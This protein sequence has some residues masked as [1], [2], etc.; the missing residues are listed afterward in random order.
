MSQVEPVGHS[1]WVGDVEALGT[2]VRLLCATQV[3]VAA[4]F[5][6]P[7]RPAFPT[8]P[9]PDSDD[10]VV[11]DPEAEGDPSTDL[12]EGVPPDDD[13]DAPPGFGD[14]EGDVDPGEDI[15]ELLEDPNRW[16]AADGMT[17]ADEIHLFL[18]VGIHRTHRATVDVR[19][20]EVGD[21]VSRVLEAVASTLEMLTVQSARLT[22]IPYIDALSRGGEPR[23]WKDV[24]TLEWQANRVMTARSTAPKFMGV[25]QPAA[26][27]APEPRNRYSPP[28]QVQAPEPAQVSV[29]YQEATYGDPEQ[30]QREADLSVQSSAFTRGL[31]RVAPKG[32]LVTPDHMMF[33]LL[34][35]VVEQSGESRDQLQVALSTMRAQLDMTRDA[36]MSAERARDAAVAKAHEVESRRVADLQSARD[37]LDAEGLKHTH[38]ISVLRQQHARELEVIRRD[39]ADALRQRD[40]EDML[41]RLTTE[42]DR[43]TERAAQVAKRRRTTVAEDGSASEDVVGTIMDAV[44]EKIT[45]SPDDKDGTAT[46]KKLAL[47]LRMTAKNDRKRKDLVS[48]LV[49][50][51]LSAAARLAR[52][53]NDS[54]AE[55]Q[56]EPDGEPEGEADEDE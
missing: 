55:A 18:G 46:A 25:P 17:G 40:H 13:D 44:M 3:R 23:E 19:S 9:D 20:L 32:T 47:G 29:P 34:N 21:V 11:V 2:W 12:S 4:R 56:G 54:L 28:P 51:D 30:D 27:P 45:G 26:P 52:E 31:A 53:L 35:V 41:D 16:V 39:H 42:R 14:I 49:K 36:L 5:D 6:S 22:F 50:R 24:K 43:A 1:G 15:D 7:S 8:S 10:A 37:K 38:E 48:D 33:A